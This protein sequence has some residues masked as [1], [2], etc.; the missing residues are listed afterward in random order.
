[1]SEQ[2]EDVSRN[3]IMARVMFKLIHFIEMF[4]RDVQ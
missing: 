4:Y 1:M 3:C 2:H